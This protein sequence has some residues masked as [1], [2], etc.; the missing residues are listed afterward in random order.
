MGA[1]A[2]IFLARPRWWRAGNTYYLTL[3]SAL[4]SKYVM[5]VERFILK[6]YA[7]AADRWGRWRVNHP[8]ENRGPWSW[9]L[10]HRGAE[11]MR[12]RIHGFHGDDA[13]Y[14]EAR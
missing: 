11:K 5:P 6:P 13:W 12:E 2:A 9:C 7:W 3:W 1:D 8:D 14:V 10:T 4:Y